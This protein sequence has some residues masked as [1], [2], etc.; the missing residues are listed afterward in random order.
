MMFSMEQCP[1]CDSDL[2]S[3]DQQIIRALTLRGEYHKI[4]DMDR[5]YCPICVFCFSDTYF[6]DELLWFD[7]RCIGD[8]PSSFVGEEMDY[9][10]CCASFGMECDC[11]QTVRFDESFLELSYKGIEEQDFYHL[12]NDHPGVDCSSCMQYMQDRCKPLCESLMRTVV[13][14][15]LPQG[16]IT[17]C[18]E[19]LYNAA[20]TPKYHYGAQTPQTVILAY[21]ETRKALNNA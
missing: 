4:E 13:N 15:V 9:L 16:N 14:D 8:P 5:W 21:P 11:P 20:N 1:R 18:T 2:P 7:E 3:N 10:V 6:I 12:N 17:P 19:Y